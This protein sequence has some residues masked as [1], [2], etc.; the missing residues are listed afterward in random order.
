MQVPRIRYE[1]LSRVVRNGVSPPIADAGPNQIGIPAGTV[2]LNGS[3]SHDPNGEALTYQWV[4]EGGPTVAISNANQAIAT[5]T[6]A[7]GQAYTFRLTVRNTD[8]QTASARTQVSTLSPVQVE[9]LFFNA[10]PS[11]INLGQSSMLSWRVT[12]AT[13]VTISPNIG[14]VNPSNGTVGVQPNDT[15]TYTLTATNANGSQTAQ[16]V[17]VVQKPQAQITVCTAVPMTIMQGESATIY[18]QTMNATS[19]SISPTVGAVGMNGNVVVSPTTTTNYT[20]TANNANGPATCSVAVTVTPAQAPRIVKFSASPLT[21]PVGS[22]STLLWVVE[23]ATK[24]TID[25]G[26][27]TVDLAG[28]ANVQP[29]N[30]TTYT[31]TASNTNGGSV[32]ATVTVNVT[33]P[34]P[35]PVPPTITSFTANPPQSPNPGT[36]VTL[37]CLANNAK[38][39]V[40]SAVGPV[41]SNGTLVVNPTVTTTYVC[42]AVGPTGLQASS[43]LTVQ[44]GNT[45]PSTGGGPAISVTS[46][47]ATCM[48]SGGSVQQSGNTTVC[49]TVVRTVNLDLTG[50]TSANPPVTFTVTS[51]QTSAVVLNPN[52]PTPTVQLSELFGDYYFTVVATDAKGLTT[53]S[54]VD[55]QYVRT[56]VR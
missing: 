50:T 19:V 2:T 32:T 55:V 6:A 21:I 43:N 16:T 51:Q 26:V 9:I 56:S 36:A 22:T 48:V 8:G 31:L 5:F 20:I 13:S 30:T 41:S 29:S 17:V 44:V 33:Q 24:V 25:Q 45:G 1:V 54:T 28:T 37:T 49:Q 46:P 11:T 35:P 14:S 3:G 38:Q 34:P 12:G 18:Y 7:A 40:I 27:G 4:Q 53:T 47:N 39:V 15:T 10:N 42:V 52:S 23:N